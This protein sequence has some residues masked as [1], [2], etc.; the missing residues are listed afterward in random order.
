M[1]HDLTIKLI[2]F[3]CYKIYGEVILL[4]KKHMTFN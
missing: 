2:F 1:S 3:T 4:I